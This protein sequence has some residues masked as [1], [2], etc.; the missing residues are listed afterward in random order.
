[1][2]PTVNIHRKNKMLSTDIRQLDLKTIEKNVW[3]EGTKRTLA[4][5]HANHG[6]CDFVLNTIAT[7]KR[8]ECPWSLV[9]FCL[10][11]AAIDTLAPHG[12]VCV[13]FFVDA[14]QKLETYYAPAYKRIV[15]VKLDILESLM[16][17]D[18]ADYILYLDSDVVFYRDPMPYLLTLASADPQTDVFFQCGEPHL[19]TCSGAT[20]EKCKNY[21]SG[22]FLT[23]TNQAARELFHYADI[24]PANT[25][26]DGDQD[27]INARLRA[28]TPV[29][30]NAL[31]PMFF[32]NG[33]HRQALP[34][35]PYVLH[36]NY[37]FSYEKKQKMQDDKNWLFGAPPTPAPTPASGGWFTKFP[38]IY[39]PRIMVDYPPNAD[40]LMET[41]VYDYLREHPEEIP[42]GWWYLDVFWTNL[43]VNKD[44]F[45]KVYDE[46]KLQSM[47]DALPRS[48]SYFTVVQHDDGIRQRLPEGTVVF[49]SG[50]ASGTHCIPL[51]Y[52][53]VDN[54]LE[55]Y[56]DNPKL[57]LASFVGSLTHPVRHRMI[58]AMAPHKDVEID[59][60]N[61]T[62]KVTLS[63]HQAFTDKSSHSIFALSPRGYGVT[64][65]RF[66]EAFKM[67]AIPVHIWDTVEWL[68]FKDIIDYKRLCLSVNV[69]DIDGLYDLM[70]GYNQQQ[71]ADMRSYYQE[72]KHLFE[73][74]GATKQLL[75]M[76]PAVITADSSS[77]SASDDA[78]DDEAINLQLLELTRSLTDAKATLYFEIERA[79]FGAMLSR[80]MTGIGI[81]LAHG[82]TPSFRMNGCKYIC[83]FN[84]PG[85]TTENPPAKFRF[86]FPT[87]TP[88]HVS[89]IPYE[90]AFSPYFGN[91]VL[92]E[93]YQFPE[94]PDRL[95]E[96]YPDITRHQ[97]CAHIMAYIASH[98]SDELLALV[99][100]VQDD[101]NWHDDDTPATKI[102]IHIRRGDKTA[103][104]PNVPET[105][106]VKYFQRLL[107]K[108]DLAPA[109]VAVYLTSDDPYMGVSFPRA[110]AAAGLSDVVVLWD[111]NETRY[112]NA[113]YAMVDTDVGLARQE[114]LTAAKNIL[115]LG[116]CD[117][118]IG[119]HN[120]Q[121]TWLGGLLAVYFNGLDTN[122]HI[123]IHAHNHE[124][125]HWAVDYHVK[126]EP[127]AS[128]AMLD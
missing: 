35:D 78:T 120:T 106:Y 113:N 30:A 38:E 81:C 54:S 60:C 45:G 107:T 39:R 4:F 85:L 14:S 64:S 122:R 114:S 17:A 58:A 51:I 77:S 103:D 57:I 20:V 99:G 93:K 72:I 19:M 105:V 88:P 125:S 73:C 101:L 26:Y 95:R 116:S 29:V 9:V 33:S 62:N 18:V 100:Q 97:W 11:Q 123:M 102:G 49:S 36:Y 115:L 50:S 108:H 21:C 128:P 90:W 119:T 76:L 86:T 87:T 46:N 2:K 71:L 56:K 43:Y 89:D 98:A 25:Q 15:F 42:D 3:V 5:T 117:Y 8:A 7:M 12:V 127:Y 63:R 34:K 118:V 37:L 91:R 74:E 92:T 111:S 69:K 94:V 22:F 52:H 82:M 126:E 41:Y 28:T 59:T 68:P 27:F 124:L 23:R 1:M 48:R 24:D 47:L 110:L 104:N 70:T 40:I 16:A 55:D 75:K 10:D 109:D 121:F 31:S 112:N 61:W 44:Q 6:Y 83:P 79:G 84:I 67:G 32:P 53:D 80:I 65:F 66:Y 13:P 96:F